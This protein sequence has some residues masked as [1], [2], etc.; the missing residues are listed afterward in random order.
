[1]KKETDMN[2]QELKAALLK[3]GIESVHLDD[4]THDAASQM[5]SA[6]NNDGVEGQIDFLIETC[7][8]TPEMIL[9]A[10]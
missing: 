4:L 6:A 2:K 10:C 1:M 9:K 7:G 3:K 5:A 8:W